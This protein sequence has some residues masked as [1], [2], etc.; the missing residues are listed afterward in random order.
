VNERFD[1]QLGVINP[2]AIK[3]FDHFQ[4][5]C[6]VAEMQRFQSAIHRGKLFIAYSH[7]GVKQLQVANVSSD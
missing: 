4:F 1:P 3:P 7:V 5:V 6:S 2:Q